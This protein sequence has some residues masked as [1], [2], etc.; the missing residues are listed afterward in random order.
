MTRYDKNKEIKVG[1][2]VKIVATQK[3]LEEIFINEDRF[4]FYW[5]NK[6]IKVTRKRERLDFNWSNKYVE[7]YGEQNWIILETD[8]DSCW[9]P[10]D[11]VEKVI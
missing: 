6:V 3:Q 9:M 11:F 7:K 5:K 2:I 1:D 10:T 8:A 4:N